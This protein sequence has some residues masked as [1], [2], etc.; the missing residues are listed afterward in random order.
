M[1]A[2][3]I[4]ILI[5]VAIGDI[6]KINPALLTESSQEMIDAGR[7]FED[8]RL[9]QTKLFL[10]SKIIYNKSASEFNI[11]AIYTAASSIEFNSL[12]NGIYPNVSGLAGTAIDPVST[13]SVDLLISGTE[14]DVENYPVILVE[15]GGEEFI[16]AFSNSRLFV[17][18]TNQ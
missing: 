14:Y 18:A 5:E 2:K 17:D 10:N 1:D 16:L 15:Y 13:Q 3:S 8:L 6:S 7:Q 9:D 4:L 12:K 11:S